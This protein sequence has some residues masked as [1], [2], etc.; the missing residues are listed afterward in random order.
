MA[1]TYSGVRETKPDRVNDYG[2]TGK[3][4]EEQYQ[5]GC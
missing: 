4:A 2:N 3:K 5:K 1:V